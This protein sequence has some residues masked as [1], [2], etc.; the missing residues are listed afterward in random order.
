[1]IEV[2][3]SGETKKPKT[4]AEE[5]LA[6][7]KNIRQ[8]GN[9]GGNT[10]IY[11]EDS[12]MNFLNRQMKKSDPV[13]T[14]LLGK[15]S[16]MEDITYLF[17]NGAI[18]PEGIHVK[19]ETLEFAPQSF[20]KLYEDMEA[21]FPE[22]NL[23]GWYLPAYD[24]IGKYGSTLGHNSRLFLLED[25][26]EAEELFYLWERSRLVKQSGYYIYYQRNEEMK[27]YMQ[28][29]REKQEEEKPRQKSWTTEHRQG[30]VTAGE[31]KQEEQFVDDYEETEP[32]NILFPVP[33]SKLTTF[34]YAA[35]TVLAIVVLV[36]GITLINNYE[37][38]YEMQETIETIAT[39]IM[40]GEKAVETEMPAGE[41]EGES[42][43][44]SAENGQQPAATGS[45]GADSGIFQNMTDN[46]TSSSQNTG[47]QVSGEKTYIVQ[48]GDTLASI[49]RKIYQ[50]TD[51]IEEIKQLNQGL[52]ENE[53][54][55]G[56][57]I[58]LP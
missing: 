5:T 20:P 46:G 41:K 33:A 54:E 25:P 4:H 45:L 47:Q 31:T 56:Q 39:S 57:K 49:S 19:G 42:P 3:Y 51:K 2:I 21:Y 6:A 23:L 11:V 34:L 50:T 26:T 38:M 43:A 24:M 16:Q 37:K 40:D 9:A 1:M 18:L 53:L 10:R 28:S 8:I 29:C 58:I 13:V 36:I 52:N 55:I 12:V 17:V 14:A 32:K 7:L 48:Q 44:P 35:S 22:A 27:A 30:S 15:E